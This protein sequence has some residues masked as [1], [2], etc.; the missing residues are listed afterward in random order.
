MRPEIARA[1]AFRRNMSEP[2]VMLWSRLK[3][4]RDQGYH[5]RRQAPFRGYFLDFVCYRA[6][7]VIEVD[8]FQHADDRQSEHDFVRDR[9]L[10]RHG[11]RVLRIWAGEIRHDLTAVMDRILAVLAEQPNACGGMADPA[12]Q[13]S[14]PHGPT[15]TA[16]RSVPPH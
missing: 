16:S 12:A 13:H 5:F 10:S 9:V 11:F 4:L 2:E 15:L 1:R 14:G 7:L 3:R 8:G 6:R